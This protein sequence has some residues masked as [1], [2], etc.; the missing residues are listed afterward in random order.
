VALLEN[1]LFV[2]LAKVVGDW[3]WHSGMIGNKPGLGLG[4]FGTLVVKSV[5]GR[6]ESIAGDGESIA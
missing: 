1:K 3:L 5:K 6:M 4:C 2:E